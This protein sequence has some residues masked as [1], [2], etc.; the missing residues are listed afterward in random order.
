MT[1]IILSDIELDF[2]FKKILKKV[3]FSIQKGE[4]VALIGKNGSGKSTIL[5]IISGLQKS[6][7]GI[8]T[9]RKGASLGYLNQESDI[10]DDEISVRNFLHQAQKEIFAA[11]NRLRELGEDMA[12]ADAKL[13]KLLS[14]Y[15]RLQNEFIQMGGYE[16]E[17]NFNRICSVFKLKELL[18]KKCGELSGGQKTIVKLAKVLLEAPDILLLDEPTNHLDISAL[19]WLENFVREYRGTV[20][21]VSHDR[22][23]V[24][25]TANKTILLYKGQ[26]EVF[27]GNYSFCIKEQE[28][29]TLIEFEQYKNQQKKIE[30]M[31]AAIKRFREWG[32]RGD[33]E[34]MFV[35]AKNIEKRLERM[36]KI[37]KPETMRKFPIQFEMEK[38]SGK[39]VLTISELNF[40][41]DE[42]NSE[43]IFENA[44]IEIIFREHICLM[45][46]NG[47]GKSTLIKLIIGEL[48]MQSGEMKLSES[49]KIGY[50]PQNVTF[51]NENESILG[52]FQNAATI[53]ENEARRILAKFFITRDDVYKKLHSLSGGERVILKLAMLMQS[54]VNF[55]ILDEPTNHLDIDTKE[56]LEESLA[57]FNGTLLF[58]S[59]DRYF[60]NRLATRKI[61]IENEILTT[62]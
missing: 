5:R 45:G 47:T 62:K 57:D 51:E 37:E 19:E 32:A 4:K 38:R 2:G 48:P 13:E 61:L 1:D 34:L 3:N 7:N 29:Q 43:K 42:N 27:D 30:A 56:L 55:L 53:H 39:R 50:I 17:E 40:S 52:A 36:E 16:A 58:I 26:T 28:R 60:I 25:K 54:S 20:V 31:Q 10:G 22:Y 35:K 21:T 12:L 44:E 41:Y 9:V 49:A 6:D 23:F 24:D 59:H 46:A 33:N 8:C 14:E 18:E 15:D 11:E